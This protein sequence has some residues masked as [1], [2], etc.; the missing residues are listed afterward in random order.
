M[1][2]LTAERFTQ[3]DKAAVRGIFDECTRYVNAEDWKGWAEMY[4]EDGLLQPPNG[5][6]VRGRTQLRAWGEAFPPIERLAFSD[7]QT[8]G[9]G[10]IAYGTSGYTLEMKDGTTDTGKQL[11]VFRRDVDGRWSVVAGSYSSD[12]TGPG[13]GGKP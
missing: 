13:T 1:A 8:W 9:E 10:S 6:T 12:L 7:V 3:Q 4:S 5:P 11:V 2:T